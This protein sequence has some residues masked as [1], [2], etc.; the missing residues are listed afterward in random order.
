MFWRSQLPHQ[1]FFKGL[2]G[3]ESSYCELRYDFCI[4]GTFSHGFKMRVELAGST[5]QR[6]DLLKNG[7][8]NPVNLFWSKFDQI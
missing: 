2:I 5:D 7:P 4:P 1:F 6:F 3:L 8:V